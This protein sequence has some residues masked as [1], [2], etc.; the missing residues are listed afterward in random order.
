MF[1][2]LDEVMVG[3][4]DHGGTHI[5]G[6]LVRF[7]SSVTFCSASELLDESSRDRAEVGRVTGCE[8]ANRCGAVSEVLA[9]VRPDRLEIAVPSGEAASLDRAHRLVHQRR[10]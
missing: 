9:C 7:R 8:L 10:H 5:W 4:L 3:R 2:G 6:A 1:D